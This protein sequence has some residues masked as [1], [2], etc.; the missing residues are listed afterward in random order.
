MQKEYGSLCL[1]PNTWRSYWPSD[2]TWVSYNA[3]RFFTIW[4]TRKAQSVSCL[5]TVQLFTTTRTGPHQAPLLMKF[6]RQ[7]YWS[8][9]PFLLS[10]GSCQPR[11]QTPD[12]CIAGKFLTVSDTRDAPFLLSIK[13]LPRW[14]SIKNL[15][16]NARDVGDSSSNPGLGRSSGG[17]NGNLQYSCLEN[18]MDRGTWWSIIYGIT[19]SRTQLSIHTHE[20]NTIIKQKKE[21]FWLPCIWQELLQISCIVFSH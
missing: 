3:G 15:S 4:A 10:R 1:N 9:W 5:V 6:S 13:R 21:H 18:L 14:L 20:S 12:F 17:R 19:N 8:G 16:A 11:D 7:E 2:Q